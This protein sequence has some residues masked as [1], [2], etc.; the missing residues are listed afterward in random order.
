MKQIHISNILYCIEDNKKYSYI[1]PN[2]GFLSNKIFTAFLNVNYLPDA[3]NLLYINKTSFKKLL[4]SFSNSIE[5]VNNYNNS[6]TSDT[7]INKK[8]LRQSFLKS[9]HESEK[10]INSLIN[11]LCEIDDI[12]DFNTV[13]EHFNF[14]ELSKGNYLNK[15]LID[16]ITFKLKN[17]NNL[18][19][20]LKSFC[21]F[22]SKV[23]VHCEDYNNHVLSKIYYDLALLFEEFSKIYP[24][25]YINYYINLINLYTNKIDCILNLKE[26]KPLLSL[27]RFYVFYEYI[28]NMNDL[29]NDICII[30]IVDTKTNKYNCIQTENIKE[31]MVNNIFYNLNKSTFNNQANKIYLDIH[32][33]K[34]DNSLTI[35][36][37]IGG[38]DE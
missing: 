17:K 38:L 9:H 34:I 14:N 1:E 33:T 8:V 32:D 21:A 36:R 4:S 30:T 31:K 7:K 37:I 18:L 5:I 19:D 28:D 11:T 27:N 12:N 15:E 16:K 23:I 13:I 10:K 29:F 24:Q 35:G 2:F 3:T 6:K 20:F 25:K 26:E 22:Y